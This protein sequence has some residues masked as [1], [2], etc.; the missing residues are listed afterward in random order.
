M[1]VKLKKNETFYI[2]EGWFEKAIYTIGNNDHNVFSKNNGVREL[3]IG[4]N[5]VKGLKYWLKAANV[6]NDNKAN[7]LTEFGKLLL[8]YDSYLDYKFSWFLI[9]YFLTTNADECP[10][11]NAIFNSNIRSFR[12]T[13]ITDVLVNRFSEGKQPVNR[14]YVES[15]LNVFI[16]SYVNEEEIKN[17]ENNYACPLAALKLLKYN[18]EK[19]ERIQPKYSM[20]DY[21]IV[22]YALHRLYSGR[23]F[24]IEDSI[25]E[26]DS[27]T[28]VFNLDKYTYLQYLDNMV[29]NGLIHIDR[30]AGLNT[31]YFNRNDNDLKQLF[32]GYFAD[33]MRGQDNV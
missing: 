22:Y 7:D 30:T 15:D 12:K 26:D 33:K 2:R 29:K 10:I 32:E 9:H 18:G 14:K 5:M 19:Y 16:R 23:P 24:E 21:R 6:I 17:P 31:V 28:K 3:G 27:P 13:E 11:A 20:L 8:D 25:K 4:S 1:T